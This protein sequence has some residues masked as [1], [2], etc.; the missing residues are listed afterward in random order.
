MESESKVSSSLSKLVAN[1]IRPSCEENEDAEF[2]NKVAK[3][4]ALE[5]CLLAEIFPSCQ[6]FIS[7]H[8]DEMFYTFLASLLDSSRLETY[9]SCNL[10]KIRE[11]AGK[12]GLEQACNMLELLN[13]DSLLGSS[14]DQ[15]F[16]RLRRVQRRHREKAAETWDFAKKLGSAICDVDSDNP[17]LSPFKTI[18]KALLNQDSTQQL[19]AL[20]TNFSSLENETFNIFQVIRK[21]ISAAST[22][23]KNNVT[24]EKTASFCL[25]VLANQILRIVQSLKYHDQCSNATSKRTDR[26]FK[27]A[28]LSELL[29]CF[30]ELFVASMAWIL[31]ESRYGN[32]EAWS[33]FQR[34]MR[35]KFLSP[36][37]RR[38][39]ID[40]TNALQEMI[41]SAKSC[42]T[43][44]RRLVA[45]T[46]MPP[47]LV[48]CA[49]YL[50]GYLFT[51][52][53]RRS[54]QL[55]IASALNE[56]TVG[57]QNALLEAVIGSNEHEED[58]IS[59]TVGASFPLSRRRDFPVCLGWPY[60]SPIQK[61]IDDYLMVVE[62]ENV[63]SNNIS[64]WN[65][66]AEMRLSFI[67]IYIVPRL[68]HRLLH[69][70]KK[71]RIIKLL[72]QLLACD[73]T[74]MPCS[75]EIGEYKVPVDVTVVCAI[76]KSITFSVCQC[77]E[78]NSVDDSFASSLFMCS[79]Y[80]AKS[81]V[82]ID[83]MR[84]KVIDWSQSTIQET[85]AKNFLELSKSEIDSTYAW[86]FFRWLES[87]AT[88]L[89]ST[90]DGIEQD[91]L[92]LRSHWREMRGCRRGGMHDES[93]NL[94]DR[95]KS[96]EQWDRLLSDF[97]DFLFP[98][99]SEI[100]PDV[101]NIYS[102]VSTKDW[103]SLASKHEESLMAWTPASPVQK[104]AKLFMA[105]VLSMS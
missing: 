75:N 65:A 96:L 54:R 85:K 101:K 83:G 58:M 53:V 10:D 2:S 87:I 102:K 67:M 68:N 93:L 29:T 77:L 43:C 4:L 55:L 57:L 80:L 92:L 20:E 13:D 8:A 41:L 56:Q 89:T 36:I 23:Q 46:I 40:V 103:Q 50:D 11:K 48:G 104:S 62:E 34:Q 52:A 86:V 22:G 81:T 64:W 15:Q 21:S 61:Y 91:L 94:D 66:V 24:F 19:D 6:K 18:G 98:S 72:S 99:K 74:P 47:S 9:P 42:I 31:R 35:D 60:E 73:V 78:Q 39:P 16:I 79:I 51:S 27:R 59:M 30:V 3:R 97:E 82:I 1:W 14:N 33:F 71:R 25:L 45:S 63:P 38:Q 26:E 88:M 28:G 37:L 12:Q 17:S 100:T 44:T 69:L 49:K 95:N 70:A 105:T 5:L 32:S 90:N 76:I 7:N 84:W